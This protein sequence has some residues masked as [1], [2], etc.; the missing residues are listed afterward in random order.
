[1]SDL[2]SPKLIWA[3][4]WLFLVLGG[5]AS[6]IVWLS[7]SDWRVFAAHAIAVWAFCRCYYFAF[8]VIEH[9]VDPNYRFAGLIDFG[10]YALGRQTLGRPRL[11]SKED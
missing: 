2:K 1:M 10:K 8:Y 11:P 9:Y 3:K 4:G 6:A 5:L 7:A